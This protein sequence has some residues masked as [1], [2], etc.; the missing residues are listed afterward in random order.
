MFTYTTTLY[1]VVYIYNNVVYLIGEMLR[2]ER[3]FGKREY[4]TCVKE[5][6]IMKEFKYKEKKY[7][8]QELKN[9]TQYLILDTLI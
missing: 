1:I 4:F 8:I 3:K 7:L 6:T 5:R 9:E 2:R